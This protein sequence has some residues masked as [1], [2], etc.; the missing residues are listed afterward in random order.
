[1]TR[2]K[3]LARGKEKKGK[4]RWQERNDM[5]EERRKT[6]KRRWQERKDMQEE[7]RKTEKRRWQERKDMQEGKEEKVED[8]ER[9]ITI[10]QRK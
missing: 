1:M 9:K 7:R 10:C 6:E 4:R 2:K 8:Q 3:R 5:Q